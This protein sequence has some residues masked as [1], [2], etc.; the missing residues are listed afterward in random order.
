MSHQKKQ[1]KDTEY[2]L[3]HLGNGLIKTKSTMSLRQADTVDTGSKIQ[4]V[5]IPTQSRITNYFQPPLQDDQNKKKSSI[6]ESVVTNKE[7]ILNDKKPLLLR[8][9][10]KQNVYLKS[11]QRLI[12]DD[13]NYNPYLNKS[14][15][16][17]YPELQS[18][19]KTVLQGLVTS[20]LS[21][22]V[23]KTMSKS[24]LSMTDLTQPVKHQT[25]SLLKTCWPSL[26]RSVQSCMATENTKLKIMKNKEEP[27]EKITLTKMM[28]RQ[29]LYNDNLKNFIIQQGKIYNETFNKGLKFLIEKSKESIKN[30]HSY[31]ETKFQEYK[32][33]IIKKNK[34]TKKKYNKLSKDKKKKYRKLMKKLN[35]LKMKMYS[36]SKQPNLCL[37]AINK[38][39]IIKEL[40]DVMIKSDLRSEKQKILTS[41]ISHT[42]CTMDK[43]FRNLKAI[44]KQH[45]ATKRYYFKVQY[46]NRKQSSYSNFRKEEVEKIFKKYKV[47]D[48]LVNI[49]TETTIIYNQKNNKM[50]IFKPKSFERSYKVFNLDPDKDSL[51]ISSCDPGINIFQTVFNLN[52][53][54]VTSI[55]D[56]TKE[57][58]KKVLDVNKNIEKLV[59]R[60][61]LKNNKGKRKL[62]KLINAKRAKV[63]NRIKDAHW[64]L[65]HY[66]TKEND[67]LLLPKLQVKNMIQKYNLQKGKRNV[68]NKKVRKECQAWS[69]GLFNQRI[70]YIAKKNGCKIFSH[71]EYYTSQSC[72]L[73][74]YFTKPNNRSFVCANSKCEF[75]LKNT[76]RDP[77]SSIGNMTTLFT[78]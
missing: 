29:I 58:K 45:N 57:L 9:V 8:A 76:F 75:N 64:K 5:K 17:Q 33:K 59:E 32:T 27:M 20:G 70:E 23:N 15:W 73:C 61:K 14:V 48:P 74:G 25:K 55:G 46:R 6:V 50:Y 49:Y 40:K 12:L 19:I 44:I 34:L 65:A 13:Q 60:K 67:V 24:M 38:K 42:Y 10:P 18:H 30:Y 2:I 56:K 53:G 11:V 68:L 51:K 63:S 28:K 39:E 77:Q 35:K 26:I 1:V 66:L 62:N 69:H 71:Q 54:V 31:R 78:M 47:D 21:S 7:M 4:I 72:C 52:N 3:L 41:K 36:K 16:E 43:A 22:S 37:F